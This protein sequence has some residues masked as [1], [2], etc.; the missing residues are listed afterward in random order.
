MT[1]QALIDAVEAKRE[2]AIRKARKHLWNFNKLMVPDF[3]KPD[4]EYLKELSFTIE[5]WLKGNINKRF[6]II[7]APPRHGKTLTARNAVLWQFGQN[8]HS[9]IMT[10]SYNAILSNLF[11]QQTRDGI[12]EEV[13]SVKFD[14]FHD[15]FPDVN[16]QYGDGSKSFWRIEGSAEKNYLATSPGGTS[17]GIGAQ[18][19]IIDDIIKNAEE[20]FNERVLDKHWFWFNNTLMQRLE[21]GSKIMLIMTRWAERDLAGRLISSRPNECHVLTYEALVNEKKKEMLSSDV[22]S[23]KRFKSDTQEMDEAI[24]QANYQQK[25]I[26][27]KGRLYKDLKTYKELPSNVVRVCSYTDMADK[28]KDYYAAVIY[29]E[30]KD[31]LA[32]VLDIIYTKDSTEITENLMAEKIIEHDVSYAVFEENNG[33]N[34]HKRDVHRIVKSKGYKKAK[35]IAFHQSKN[36]EARII[37]HSAHV[38]N[39]VFFPENWGDRWPEAHLSMSKYQ[40]EGNN[41]NDD[42]QDALTGVVETLTNTRSDQKVNA[43]T[44]IDTYRRMGL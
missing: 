23:Y 27:V 35:I 21:E 4:I 20:A 1:T 13:D 38:Q 40:R 28:G 44:A 12:A 10:G 37:S 42:L 26:D 36:K 33:G 32:Y 3:Y 22:L 39:R 30:T 41:A 6:L 34:I 17:T 7:N 25:P 19:L 43:K 14:T 24:V 9:K 5:E 29:A 18:L 15:V 8:P 31:K 16:I 2:L 11:A